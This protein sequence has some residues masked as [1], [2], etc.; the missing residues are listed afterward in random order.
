MLLLVSTYIFKTKMLLIEANE[1][2]MALVAPAGI[3][4][5]PPVLETS[6]RSNIL[7]GYS[8]FT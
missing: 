2:H 6:V 5:A 7:K 8:Y 3:E 1:K 4:P